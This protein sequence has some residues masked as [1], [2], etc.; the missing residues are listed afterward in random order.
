MIVDL[1]FGAQGVFSGRIAGK[2]MNEM[3]FVRFACKKTGG[4][5]ICGGLAGVCGQEYGRVLW[6]VCGQENG[7]LYGHICGRLYGQ[8]CGRAFA[9]RNTQGFFLRVCEQ[10][11]KRFYKGR[12]VRGGGGAAGRNRTRG[13]FSVGDSAGSGQGASGARTPCLTARIF[14]HMGFSGI[15]RDYKGL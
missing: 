9:G 7:R 5:L 12:S 4:A 3:I 13:A 14:V 1:V 6:R 15:P 8:E 11:Y 10:K 2:S